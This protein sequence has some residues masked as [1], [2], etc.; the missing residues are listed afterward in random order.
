MKL[1]LPFFLAWTVIVGSLAQTAVADPTAEA[2]RVVSPYQA[3]WTAPP[4][5]TPANHSVD[6]PLLGNGDVGVCLGG[7]PESLR[8]Y[9]SKNDFWRLKSQYGQSGPRVFGYLDVAIDSLKGADYRVEQD[10]RD[11]TTT[12]T[13][14]QD[15]L[16]VEVKSWVAAT[17]NVLVIELSAEGGQAEARVQLAAAGG[18]GSESENGRDGGIFHAMRKFEQNVDIPTEVAAAM[19]IIGA[20]VPAFSLTAGQ[21]ATVVVVMTSRFKQ[22]QPLAYVKQRVGKVDPQTLGQLRQSHGQ[23]WARYWDRSWVQIGDPVLEKAYYQALYSM[24]ANSRDPKFSPGI[25]GTW[26]TTDSPAWAGDYHTNYNH[27]APFYALHSAN[28]IEQAD[29]EDAP[30]LDFRRRGRWYA[31]NVTKTRGVLYPVG[32]GPLGIETTVNS[33]RH[34]EGHNRELGGCSFSSV[35]TQPTAWSTWPSAGAPRTIQPTRRRSIRSCWKWSIS[36]R[37]T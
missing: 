21:T 26:V 24:G 36:G 10:I 33:P 19:K 35:P 11:G 6:A 27:V 12:A 31:A 28:R 18:G 1:Q 3:V 37:I 34:R 17:E 8:F 14:K 30:I 13:L 25:F 23:W 4:S 32:I 29:P 20:N 22:E 7:P 9:L 16:T 15:N 5:R 2:V